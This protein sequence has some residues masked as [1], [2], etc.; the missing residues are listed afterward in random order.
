MSKPSFRGRQLPYGVADLFFEDAARKTRAEAALRELF[1]RSGYAQVISPTFEFFEPLEAEASPE[2][3]DDI[4]RFFDPDGLMLALRADPTIPIARIVASKLYSRPL[5]LRLFYITEVFRHEEPK[6]ALRREFTQA[7]VELIGVN[8]PGADAEVLALAISALR[9]IGLREFRLRIG[10]MNLVNALLEELPLESGRIEAVKRALEVKSEQQLLD[11]VNGDVMRPALREALA[12]L[13]R[14]SGG[15]EVLDRA[16][17]CAVNP[18]A[19]AALEHLR[20]VYRY[21]D[22]LG[23]E[24]AITLDLGMVRGMAY[25]TGLIF[26][27]FAPGIGFAIMSGGRYDG[28]L[29][30]F[31][32]DLPALGFA[33]G[34]ERALAALELQGGMAVDL[35]PRIV[36]ELPVT[37]EQAKRVQEAR[38]NG[39]RVEQS[40]VERSRAELISFARMR[41]AREVWFADG[42]VEVLA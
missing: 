14:L 4:Y 7:G 33:I 12:A 25:Y 23:C 20:R 5:P 24:Q 42:T 3:R 11:V 37:R 38:A 40:I 2:V 30:H 13:P 35:A 39:C 6:A 16:G 34:V 29:S 17:C 21:L 36:A 1:D 41:G 15:G 18:K 9:A 26:E 32:R 31:G 27:G 10:A 22:A 28:L 8:S 19:L